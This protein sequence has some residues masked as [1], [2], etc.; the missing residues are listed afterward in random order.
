VKPKKQKKKKKHQQHKCWENKKPY[1]KDAK[2]NCFPSS[3]SILY[4]IMAFVVLDR[5]QTRI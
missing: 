4:W 2:K 3:D 5:C 1:L